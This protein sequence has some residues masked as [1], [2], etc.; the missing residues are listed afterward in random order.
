M[1][2]K[3]S[4]LNI[5]FNLFSQLLMLSLGI[6][7]PKLFLVSFGSEVNGAVNSISQI[8][9]CIGLLEAGV[10]GV[11]T[12]ALYKTVV[13]GDHEKSNSILSA[14]ARYY[15]KMGSYYILAVLILAIGYPFLIE[16][17]IDKLTV[18][19][20]IIFTGL[21]G[22]IN[23]FLQFKYTVILNAEGRNYVLTNINMLVN[24]LTSVAKIVLL[25]KGFNIIAVQFAQFLITLFRIFILNRYMKKEYSW[26]DFNVEPDYTAIEQKNAQLIHQVAYMVFSNTDILVLTLITQDLKLVSVYSIY[27]M[28]IGVLDG[29]ISSVNGGLTFAFGQ[30]YAEDKEKYRKFFD[31][32][33][34]LFM[35]GVF[36][37]FIVTSY[38]IIP[39][40]S[41][42]TEGITDVNY[43]DKLLSTLFI[44]MKLFVAMRSQCY[45][46]I[47]ISGNFKTTQNSSIIEAAINLIASIVLVIKFNIYGVILGT[48]IGLIY[49]NT[50]CINFANKNVLNRSPLIT[51]KRWIINMIL[52]VAAIS[53]QKFFVLPT[54]SYIIIVFGAIIMLG[55]VFVVMLLINYL[56]EK[57]TFADIKSLVKIFFRRT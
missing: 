7:I 34:V 55:I 48:I 12:Q 50:Y 20:I 22:A 47:I 53:I 8:F 42:Y 23:F 52:F 28:L 33:E 35:T 37:I 11:T 5:F 6:I 57:E 21:G 38:Y 13:N 54:N 3:R 44:I 39:F 10:G 31:C 25:M 46:A 18:F 14:A 40:M 32:Y 51:Y 56:F 17:S 9:T 4:L 43:L 19:F 27:N 26:I 36:S 1:K 15:K 30:I 45:N 24:V 2:A 16:T 49:R 29:V 41:L